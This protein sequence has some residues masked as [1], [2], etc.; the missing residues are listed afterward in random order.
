MS[1]RGIRD[2]IKSFVPNWLSN[3]LK[4]NTAFRVLYVIAQM[5]DAMVETMIEG[6]RASQPGRGT[7]TADALIGQ[8]R[9]ILR[10][11]SETDAQYEARLRAWLMLWQNA[12]SDQSLIR[13]IQ[14][15][16]GPD[17]SGIPVVRIVDRRGDF[18]SIDAAGNITQTRDPAWNWDQYGEPARVNW[19][20]D[21]WVIVYVDPT[22]WPT[23]S[24]LTD[25]AW[26]AAWG[27]Y[28]GSGLGHQVP[29]A[30]VDGINSIIASF[31]GAHTFVQAVVISTD[32][33]LFVPGALSTSG[34][35]TGYWGWFSFALL[36]NN[37]QNPIR[38]TLNAGNTVR[39]WAPPNG[40]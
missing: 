29:R 22:R 14:G 4:A 8:S 9:G 12:G 19:W 28:G 13:L 18:T 35:P 5:T 39:Y 30:A 26:L 36:P 31:K 24:N 17:A 34:D 7:S 27:T 33:S 16:L 23:Y 37:I 20:S 10:G 1:G 3:R 40:G 32:P 21:L 15:F 2:S 11:L 25:A 38:T 6:V